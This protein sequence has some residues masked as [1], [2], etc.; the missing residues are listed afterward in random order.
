MWQ[1]AQAYEN[2]EAAFPLYPK[3]HWVHEVAHLM[4]RQARACD[5]AYNPAS[6]SCSL[7]EDFIGRLAAITRCV[8]PRIIARRTLQRYLAHIQL[9]WARQ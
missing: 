9:A 3:L 5:F 2:G 8:S 4:R 1:A 6:Y 7:D